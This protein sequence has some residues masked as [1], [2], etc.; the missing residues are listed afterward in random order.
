M[1]V[2]A[3]VLSVHAVED[4]VVFLLLR[5]RGTSCGKF[6][7]ELSY[8]KMDLFW[9]VFISRSTKIVAHGSGFARINSKQ[10]VLKPNQ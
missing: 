8:P 9:E 2:P 7:K 3:A 1:G 10:E 4:A 5:R 6:I